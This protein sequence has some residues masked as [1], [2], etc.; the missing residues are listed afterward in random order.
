MK[1]IG[2]LL[3]NVAVNPGDITVNHGR[4]RVIIE[5]LVA[6]GGIFT[7]RSNWI[8]L[9]YDV[10]PDEDGRNWVDLAY[11]PEVID[12]RMSTMEKML[13]PWIGT[14]QM[15]AA[16]ESIER[17]GRWLGEHDPLGLWKANV[18]DPKV[19]ERLWAADLGTI[20]DVD[21]LWS[22]TPSSE[23]PTLILEVGGGY[24]RL[25]EAMLNLFADVKYVLV[26]GVPGSLF[27]SYEYLR[28]ACPTA[29][30]GS[31]Y[32]DDPFDME[33]FDCY[34]V[35]SWHF[36][37]L[38]TS[39]YDVCVNIESFQEMGQEQV[40]A[41]LQ[42]FD[43]VS[44]PGTV[45]YVSNHRDAVVKSPGRILPAIEAWKYPRSWRQVLCSNTPRSATPNHPTEI[46]VKEPGDWSKANESVRAAHR[47]H[48]ERR[49]AQ[50]A[51]PVRDE[52]YRLLRR[53]AVGARRR[54]Q[55][56]LSRWSSG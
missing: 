11:T 4:L 8:T 6:N 36:E 5:D 37:A 41:F 3:K 34:V 47:W 53:M 2:Q 27:Y 51:E 22:F 7:P 20:L 1:Q 56:S 54:L 52:A 49:T 12:A 30:I 17:Y 26:D 15:G 46:F 16:R 23:R 31:Y 14:H 32:E 33:R 42:I 35:P 38:N 19:A 10:K 50:S 18:N 21:L 28:R 29:R 13:D 24:G 45:I 55:T 9:D 40:D 39:T 44:A 43:D 25:A 48:V